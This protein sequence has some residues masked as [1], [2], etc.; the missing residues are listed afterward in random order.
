MVLSLPTCFIQYTA[1]WHFHNYSRI[2]Y[3]H[4][5]VEWRNTNMFT[6][7]APESYVFLNFFFRSFFQTA[8]D[9]YGFYNVYVPGTV[10]NTSI[11]IIIILLSSSPS[12]SQPQSC[13]SIKITFLLTCAIIIQLV[14]TSRDA[15]YRNNNNCLIF[16][17]VRVYALDD[18]KHSGKLNSDHIVYFPCATL[19]F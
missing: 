1:K 5:L 10:Q 19:I 6:T 11:I 9:I 17:I 8:F 2:M 14:G 12:S 13:R 7:M 18:F 15:S 4:L 3:I 16:I